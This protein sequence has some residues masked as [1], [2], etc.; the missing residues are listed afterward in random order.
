MAVL[1]AVALLSL[2]IWIVLLAFRGGFWLNN[3]RLDD[4]SPSEFNNWPA[5][6]AV[7][8]ARN[9]AEI[10]PVTLRS[11]LSQ[12]YPGSF[13][14]ILV[15]DHSNDGTAAIARE[16]ADTLN[17]TAQLTVLA[18]QPLPNGW[19]GKLWAMEQGLRRAQT[20]SPS[21]E[22]LLLTDADIDRDESN[23]QRL[24]AKAQQ[25]NLDLVSLMVLLRCQSFW[26]KLLIPAF[27]FFFAKLYPFPWANNPKKSTAAAAGGCILIRQSALTRIGGI[28][29][30]K[31]AL[32]DDCAIAQ[33][34]KSTANTQTPQPSIWLGLT[35]LT[36][37]LR[38][39]P[40]LASIWDMVAR[41][42]YTQLNYSPLLL[43]G[44]LVGMIV[45]YWVP[46]LAFFA[47]MA[48]GNGFSALLGGTIWLLMAIAYFPTIRLYNLSVLWV[49]S[50]PAIACLY[51]LMTLDSALRHWQG[52]GGTWKG[53]IYSRKLDPN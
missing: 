32:I 9:E 18:S 1:S 29:R 15:D 12:E 16:I 30:I 52:R 40:T 53:R 41:T 28:A 44:T 48:T 50:L 23:L 36:R 38:P 46:P 27:V 22:Y 10:L 6:C 21:P 31:D 11:L 2:S 47:G 42:A 37:S 35:Q 3:Q 7:I 8:P 14:I 39:Y 51:T 34:V 19:T 33:A 45:V 24:V 43:L 25:E 13:R 49:F 17:Q 20:L 26:E 5:V 4:L